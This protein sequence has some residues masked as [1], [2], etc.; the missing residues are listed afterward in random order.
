M[1]VIALLNCDHRHELNREK[2]QSLLEK[3]RLKDQIK[4]IEADF[5]K[6]TGRQLTKEDREYHREDFEKYKVIKAK[7]K[8]LEALM[9]KND[10]KK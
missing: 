5:F 7:L 10:S 8:L 6:A 1:W 9:E 3:S 4:K 2:E